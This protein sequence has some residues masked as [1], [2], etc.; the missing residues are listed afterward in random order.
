[1][2]GKMQPAELLTLAH[3]MRSS[4]AETGVDTY[5]RMFLVAAAELEARANELTCGPGSRT[6][7]LDLRH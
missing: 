7:S 2:G 1:M 3:K 5:A 6:A 4:A